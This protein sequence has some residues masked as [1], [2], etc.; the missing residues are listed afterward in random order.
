VGYKLRCI[1]RK[2]KKL[3]FPSE[4]MAVTKNNKTNRKDKWYVKPFEKDGEKTF[5][6]KLLSKL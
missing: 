3:F 5:K 1:T 2:I 6:R 4:H